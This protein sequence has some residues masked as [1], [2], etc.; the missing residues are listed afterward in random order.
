MFLFK[1]LCHIATVHQCD[2]MTVDKY[3]VVILRDNFFH[4]T[5]SFLVE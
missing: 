4:V 3:A 1:V 5:F 2:I